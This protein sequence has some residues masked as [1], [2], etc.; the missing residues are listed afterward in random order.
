MVKNPP[1]SEGDARDSVSVPG[2]GRSPGGGHGNPL[3]HSCLESPMDR[4]AWWAA[5][6][7]VTKNRTRLSTHTHTY[8]PQKVISLSSSV[9]ALHVTA[10]SLALPGPAPQP[11]EDLAVRAAEVPVPSPP[12]A[13]AAAPAVLLSSFSDFLLFSWDTSLHSPDQGFWIIWFR[14]S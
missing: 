2:W 8:T 4:G 9:Q 1:A 10:P 6:R 3:Q 11:T 7:G 13:S 14:L 5:I 12:A